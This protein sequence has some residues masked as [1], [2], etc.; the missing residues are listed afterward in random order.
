M[1]VRLQVFV[2]LALLCCVILLLTSPVMGH[3]ATPPRAKSF[4]NLLILTGAIWAT[5]ANVF[6]P[7][8]YSPKRLL[9]QVGLVL[10][11][12]DL[13]SLTSARLC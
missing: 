4:S 1:R 3:P 13:I 6:T 10:D 7:S 2:A 9:H 12:P 5:A 8:E 11:S